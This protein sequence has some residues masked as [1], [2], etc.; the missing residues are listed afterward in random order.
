MG[1]DTV[2]IYWIKF[3]PQ[4]YLTILTELHSIKEII[5]ASMPAGDQAKLRLV[6]EKLKQSA[7][8]LKAAVEANRVALAAQPS[9]DKGE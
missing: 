5:A 7:D 8:S 1:H 4:Q 9:T 2:Q 3:D 6:T